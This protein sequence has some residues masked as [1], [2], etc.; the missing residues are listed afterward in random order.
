MFKVEK[1]RNLVQSILILRYLE[2]ELDISQ[3]QLCTRQGNENEQ[4]NFSLERESQAIEEDFNFP[5]LQD[6]S[7]SIHDTKGKVPIN[8]L[9]STSTGIYHTSIE[10]LCPIP[11]V[12][13]TSTKRSTSRKRKSIVLTDTPMKLELEKAKEKREM[14]KKK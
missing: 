3:N 5:S 9:P 1:A 2:N 12:N 13:A 14:A 6:E 7:T 11:K 10:Q 8:D 4:E